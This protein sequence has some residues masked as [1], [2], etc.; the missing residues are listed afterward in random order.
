MSVRHFD[1]ERSAS[2]RSSDAA[3][4][5]SLLLLVGLGFVALYSASSG[6]AERFFGDGNYF[7]KKQA[8][9]GLIGILL[10]FIASYMDLELLRRFIQPLVLGT[11]FLCVLTFIP[12]IGMTKNGAARWI[13]LGP[14]S[15]QPSELVKMVLPLYL[16]HIFAK[17]EERLDDVSSGVIPPALVSLVFCALVYSQNNFST[18]AFI[19]VNALI[20]FFLAGV[21][22]RHFILVALVSLPLGFLLIFTKEHRVRRLLTF[23]KPEWDPLGAGYQVR[24]SIETIASGSF[25]GKGLGQGTRK[26][27]SVPEI[28]SDFVFSAVSEEAGYLGVCLVFGLFAFFAIRGYLSAL[29]ATDTFKRL[30]GLALVTAIVSQ[31]LINVSVV[32]GAVPATGIPLPFFSAGG[33]SL[34]TT[35]FAA[36]LIVNISRTVPASEVIDV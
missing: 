30:L 5:A 6:F 33:S 8:A 31:A 34:A 21:R 26:L 28:H 13:R 24:A 16:A 1:L 25:W 19:G 14:S 3:L 4:I 35:L 18:A 23:F 20:L 32:I 29:K 10:F 2:G 7:I 15:Y 11:M 17:K 27:A 22:L 36:G 12:G 9:F